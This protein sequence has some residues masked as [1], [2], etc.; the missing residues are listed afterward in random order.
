MS[1]QTEF[2]E[3]TENGAT[4]GAITTAKSI[5]PYETYWCKYVETGFKT[6]TNGTKYYDL[7]VPDEY[8]EYWLASRCVHSFTDECRFGMHIMG[9]GIEVLHLYDSDD[10][11]SGYSYEL[12]PVVS[13]SSDLIS[14]NA[15][16]GFTVQ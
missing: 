15:T 2:V 12:F 8:T 16:N 10:Y 13:L 4:N 11:T 3:K 6:A 9:H 7:F 1:E 14:G 5:Q